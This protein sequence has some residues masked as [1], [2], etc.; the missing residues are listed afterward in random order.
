MDETRA[1]P[2]PPQG[3][4]RYEIQI[5][6]HLATRWAGWFDGVQ[7]TRQS[8]G[9]TLLEGPV[10]DQAA[11]HGLLQKVRDTGLPLICVTRIKPDRGTGSSTAIP[12]EHDNHRR[13]TP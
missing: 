2:P 3:A 11:L 8:D 5:E 4:G 12:R 1:T 13:S 9:T 6:G 7:L 10:E